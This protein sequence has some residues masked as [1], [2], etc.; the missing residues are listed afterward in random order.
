LNNTAQQAGVSAGLH[1]SAGMLTN[2]RIYDALRSFY[3]SSDDGVS[4]LE[5]ESRL[6]SFLDVI[7]KYGIENKLRSNNRHVPRKALYR[8]R[9]YLV[10]NY[11]QKVALDD[12]TAITGLTK[13]HFVRSFS[14]VYGL[15]PHAYLTHVRISQARKRLIAGEPL[16]GSEIGFFDQSH[17]IRAFRKTLGTTPARYA[18]AKSY[19]KQKVSRPAR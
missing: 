17:F 2:P 10:A 16:I 18:T 7:F 13:S 3:R 9:E 11:D 19:G 4:L 8:A 1:F 15:S 12:L 5:R 14:R 6:A